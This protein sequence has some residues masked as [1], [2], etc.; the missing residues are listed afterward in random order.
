MFKFI[1]LIVV[2]A[3]VGATKILESDHTTFFDWDA[4][5]KAVNKVRRNIREFKNACWGFDTLRKVTSL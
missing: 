1:L 2:V 5:T 3:T 4:I